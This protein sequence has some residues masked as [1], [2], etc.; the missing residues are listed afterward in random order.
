MKLEEAIKKLNSGDCPSGLLLNLR[1]NSIGVKGAQALADALASRKCPSGL[2]L[3]LSMN[4]IG[5]EG[6]Q[7]LAEVIKINHTLTTLNLGSNNIGAE[8][9]Q[10][11]AKAL[12]TNN[13]LT[14]LNLEG[15]R[16]GVEGVRA[17]AEAF[18]TNHTLTTLI[19]RHNDIRAECAQALAKALEKQQ[20]SYKSL[21]DENAKALDKFQQNVQLLQ[22]GKVPAPLQRKTSLQFK[23]DQQETYGQRAKES[24]EAGAKSDFLVTL[25]ATQQWLEH[26]RIQLGQAEFVTKSIDELY[27]KLVENAVPITQEVLQLYKS[28]F[29]KN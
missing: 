23:K 16:I 18:K 24:E 20:N 11:L 5:D 27:D 29:V 4:E 22:K 2:N 28:I 13:T 26:T 1:K 10:A 21:Q 7:A 9:A 25:Q 12:E 19:L 3:D 6:A 8:S 15:S 17:L 14:T